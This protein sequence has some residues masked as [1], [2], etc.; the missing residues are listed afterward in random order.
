MGFRLSRSLFSQ[1]VIL[2]SQWNSGYQ[3][4]FLTN[5]FLFSRLNSGYQEAFLTNFFLFSL[6]NSGYQEAFLTNFFLF[7]GWNSRDARLGGKLFSFLEFL[8]FNVY[9]GI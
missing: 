1:P 3:E 2:F 6:W 9:A 8:E 7:S 4:A 5:F